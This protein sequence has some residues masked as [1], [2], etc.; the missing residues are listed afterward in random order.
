MNEREVTIDTDVV[1]QWQRT[2]FKFFPYAAL[3]AGGWWV[4]RVNYGFPEHDFATLFIDGAAVA[5]V[6]ASPDDARPLVAG[7]GRL[8]MTHP[9]NAV[10]LQVMSRS[11]AKQVVGAVAEFVNY[12]SEWGDPC[13][14]CGSADRDPLTP[15]D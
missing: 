11:L 7:I 5:D 4:I 3:Q 14:W 15:E 1:P 9:Q 8:F 2:G 13:D 12:G 10:E 6:T